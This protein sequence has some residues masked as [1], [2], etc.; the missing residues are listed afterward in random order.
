MPGC[1]T[2]VA[3]AIH[4]NW[5]LGRD[6]MGM[7]RYGTVLY[8]VDRCTRCAVSNARRTLEVRELRRRY[9]GVMSVGSGL[10]VSRKFKGSWDAF[11]FFSYETSDHF[12]GS[13]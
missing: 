1:G 13:E 10:Q 9:S 7:R 11:N 4:A 12:L 2:G 6:L 8:M 3:T 5:I